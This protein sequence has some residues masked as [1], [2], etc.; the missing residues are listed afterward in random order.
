MFGE[1]IGGLSMYRTWSNRTNIQLLW[2]RNTSG[3]DDWEGSSIFG[4]SS[5]K[6]FYVSTWLILGND[7]GFGHVQVT[8]PVLKVSF[9]ST[10]F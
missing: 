3:I 9:A 5:E 8:E 2:R 7:V 4:I 10:H 6:T 1:H